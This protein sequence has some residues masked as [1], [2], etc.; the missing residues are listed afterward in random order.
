[1]DSGCSFPEDYK[2]FIEV[3]GEGMF[4]GRKQYSGLRI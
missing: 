2:W 4:V 1:M 3:Y